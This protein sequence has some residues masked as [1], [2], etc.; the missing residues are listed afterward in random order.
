[1]VHLGPLMSDPSSSCMSDAI[2]PSS[3]QP[4]CHLPVATAAAA[5]P[6]ESAAAVDNAP[7]CASLPAVPHDGA[8]RLLVVLSPHM[9]PVPPLVLQDRSVQEGLL[10]P[11][12]AH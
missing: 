10:V 5:P 11:A 4:S 2:I 1:M 9:G 8:V 7:C 6:P 12:G 3:S